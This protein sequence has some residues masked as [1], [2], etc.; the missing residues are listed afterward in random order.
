MQPVTGFQVVSVHSIALLSATPLRLL[1]LALDESAEF[2]DLAL[3]FLLVEVTV[4]QEVEGRDRRLH[5][6]ERRKQPGP[7]LPLNQQRMTPLG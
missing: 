4:R 7:D 2:R 5:S 6:G 1:E 3:A